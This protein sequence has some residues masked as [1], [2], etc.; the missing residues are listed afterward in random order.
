KSS[1]EINVQNAFNY[2]E[3]KKHLEN[4]N[5]SV[6]N[7]TGDIDVSSALGNRI[8]VAPRD[9]IIEGG[10]KADGTRYNIKQNGNSSRSYSMM[11][12]RSSREINVQNAFNYNEFKKHLENPNVSVINLTGDIDVSSALGNRIEVAPR[13]L[14]IE[15]GKKADG[16]RYNIKQNGNSS[17]SYSM[18]KF[19]N[20]KN[21][22]VTF[23]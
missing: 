8:E 5:V 17:R 4:P 14:I 9:L 6:I 10:K 13:D 20:T 1:R 19:K 7:L 23:R 21:A 15:G 16:T 3:F 11:K 2:N 22:T 12:F 18:M